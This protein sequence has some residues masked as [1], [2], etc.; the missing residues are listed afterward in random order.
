MDL[1]TSPRLYAYTGGKPFDAAKPTVVFLHGAQHDHSVWILQSRYLAHHGYG[2]L[3]FDLPG[4]M[5]SEGP[6]LET[7]EAI[8]DRIAEALRSAG[9]GRFIAVGQ[10]MGS[11]IALEL[12]KRL[13]GAVRG[14]ALVAT[15]FPMR[16]A[17]PLLNATRE[18][19]DE[20]MDM[21][22]VWSH[23]PSIAGFDRKPSNPAP[24]FSTMWQNLRL[25]QRIQRR[26]GGNVL[27]TDF[28]ACS[29]YAAGLETAA[30]LQ[31]PVLFVLGS[32][33]AMTPPRAA[34]ALIDACR[35]S[36]VVTLPHS[37]HSL[38]AENPDGVRTAIADFARSAFAA[39]AG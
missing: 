6:P 28:V 22:N 4:H 14:V 16:V 30:A 20:A 5:R 13:P 11:L 36:R 38:M 21:I 23:S 9:V 7:V 12:A 1:A 27:P 19:P 32:S 2:V 17:E 33:D 35:S 26:N 8:A 15:A 25:M 10:S 24:G 18:A 37:G 39:P 34:K 3:A 29:R 31:C